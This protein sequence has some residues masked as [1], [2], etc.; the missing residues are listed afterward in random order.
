MLKRDTYEF[1]KELK[2]N[3][4]REWF[5]QNKAWYE[6]TRADFELLV[7]QMISGLTSFDP[8]VANLEPKK[9]IFRIYRDTRFS[10]DKTPYKTHYGAVFRVQGLDKSSGYYLHIDP[11]ESFITCGHYMLTPE[12][13]KKMRRGI[14]EDFETFS[15]ILNEKYFKKE[16]GDLFRDEDALQR[17]PNGF[18]KNH[19]AAEY[20]KLKHFY[21]L[22]A[23][24]DDIL[25]SDNFV[26]H[27]LEI[28]KRMLPLS[29]FLN[30]ILLD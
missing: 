1:L 7:A 2:E 14:Y 5:A 25:F 15:S 12:Q 20:M 16:I 9:C 22:K 6:K 13:L 26:P 28:Y 4:D 10:Q 23:I 30:D 19:P 21:V 27:A 11:E 18:D 3:N 29:D 24:P 17:V 8:T